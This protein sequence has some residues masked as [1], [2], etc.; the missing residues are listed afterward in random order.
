MHNLPF[1]QRSLHA[2]YI[3]IGLFGS[4]AWA[5]LGARDTRR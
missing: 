3:A 5:Y 4:L 2:S 1:L